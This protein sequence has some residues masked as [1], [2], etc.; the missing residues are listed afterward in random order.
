MTEPFPW[1]PLA[2]PSDGTLLSESGDA[3]VCPHGHS[4]PV[5]D[6][7]PR[8]LEGTGGYA[9]AFGLQWNVY[10]RTQLDSTTG[11]TISRD[12]AVRCL[13]DSLWQRLTK[14]EHTRV[15]EVGCGAGRFTEVLLGTRARVTSVDMSSA[16]DA[17]RAN[18]PTD[19]RHRILQADALRLPFPPDTFDVVFC[20]GVVQH[21]PNPEQCIHALYR[22]VAPGGYL[23]FDH[24]T[25]SLSRLTKTAPLFRQVLKRLPPEAGLR[26]TERL[27]RLFFPLHRVARRSHVAQALVSRVSPVLSYYHV[28]PLNDAQQRDWALLDTHDSLTD[29][30]KHLRTARQLR[31]TLASLG[32]SDIDCRKDGNGIEVRCRKP[33]EVSI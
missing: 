16:V 26:W 5:R 24:Y 1:P 27:V 31:R 28:L 3:L 10:R 22:Q 4:W 13:G 30:Y 2:C 33:L 25:W 20:L 19:H 12:R 9:D 6:G 8:M 17:N 21:T 29:W 14:D 32:A 7:V 11:L 15:L 23:V 18:F